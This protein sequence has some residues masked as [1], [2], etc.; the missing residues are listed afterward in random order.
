M[1]D[2]GRFNKL[3]LSKKEGFCSHLNMLDITNPDYRN[4]TRIY[5][6]F[7]IK[8][9][10]EYHDLYFQSDTLLMFDVFNSFWNM[11]LETY[12]LVSASFL[13]VPRLA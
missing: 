6:D 4:A 5:K 7:E 3:L 11:G 12:V 9:V 8:N 13:S 2:S 1:D 10:V